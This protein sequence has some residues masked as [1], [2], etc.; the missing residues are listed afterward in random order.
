[1]LATAATAAWLISGCASHKVRCVLNISYRRN[2]E[3]YLDDTLGF[4]HFDL[5]TPAESDVVLMG[6]P[7]LSPP[8]SALYAAEQKVTGLALLARVTVST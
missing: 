2:P 4:T 7:S 5:W 8:H 1:M 3:S 6:R